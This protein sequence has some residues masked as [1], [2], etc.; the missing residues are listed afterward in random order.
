MRKSLLATALVAA[1][2]AAFA[3]G[4]G[5]NP[6]VELYGILDIGVERIDNGGAATAT[7]VSS[8]ISSGSR[9]GVRGRENLGNGYSAIFTVEM[10]VEADTGQ[11][12][13]NS[14][15]YYCG[16]GLC[17][18]V[19][20][21]GA[22]ASLPAASQAQIVGG[23]SALN[24]NLL[25]AITTVNSVGATF[26]RQAFA[27]LITPFGAVLLGR[28]YTP[29]YEILNKFNS[30]ADATAGQFGQGYSTIAI[31]ANN[32]IQ[33][34]AEAAG[35]TVSAMY[36]FG[37]SDGRRA[38]RASAPTGGDDFL[39]ANIQYATG[40]FSVGVGYNRSK[41]V[42]YAR[43]NDS[44][45]GLETWNVGATATLGGIRLFAQYMDRKNDNPILRP[46][47]LQNLIITTGG[48]LSAI[49]GIV[50][51]LNVNPWDVDGMRGL[52]GPSRTK[53]YHLGATVD[54]GMGT[55]H[56]AFNTAK[57]TARSGWA[58]TDAKV[59]HMAVAYF[60][61]LS[62]RTQLYGVYAVANNKG[63]A[64]MALASA[65]YAGGLTVAPGEDS[66]ALQLGMRH[67]F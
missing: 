39:G 1:F 65:G 67:S 29:G 37:G 43:P 60:H 10:R 66:S 38:E 13:N 62:R 22:V 55:V 31:R 46:E 18:G 4:A 59:D 54:V 14:P 23:A 41:V 15:L 26:D 45:T 27:G 61:N 19:R 16:T 48:N 25:Q 50:G 53:I 42:P 35:L 2:P 8:G 6:N 64:R 33:Y 52:T 11:T 47:D 56:A 36:G 9:L 51:G 12:T 28:Q 21:V 63:S 5:G 34:R 3:Q 49:V 32:A 58:T 24:A 57:D 17:P 7:R 40:A 30:F 44:L 20:A